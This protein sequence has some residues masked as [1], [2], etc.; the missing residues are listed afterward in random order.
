MEE[1]LLGVGI[2]FGFVQVVVWTAQILMRIGY[3]QHLDGA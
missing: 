1:R 3:G 2:A